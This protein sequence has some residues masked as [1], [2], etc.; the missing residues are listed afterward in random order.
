MSRKSR[1]VRKKS[2]QGVETGDKPSGDNSVAENEMGISGPNQ[3]LEKQLPQ[4]EYLLNTSSGNDE[5]IAACEHETSVNEYAN[6][7]SCSEPIVNKNSENDNEDFIYDGTGDFSGD[8]QLTTTNEVDFKV[9]T[10]VSA[11]ANH[12]IVEKICWLLKFYKS[13]SLATN[14]FIICMLRRISEDLEL[15]SMLYQV[16]L[17]SIYLE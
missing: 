15:Q 17:Q 2:L 8:E 1:K 10:V 6:S 5:D 16:I 9:S 11:L 13:N 3:L 4:K 7:M 12:N 14:H